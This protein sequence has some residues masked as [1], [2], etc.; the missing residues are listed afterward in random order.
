M[1]IRRLVPLCGGIL[2][3]PSLRLSLRGRLL[4]LVLLAI[5]PAYGL[6]LFSARED[7]RAATAEAQ[8]QT[9]QVA[10]IVA[11]EQNRLIHE[12]EQLLTTLGSLPLVRDADLLPR[13]SEAIA[14]IR[15]QNPMYGNLGVVDASGNM[16]CSAL[17]FKPGMNVADRSWFQRA[18]TR[19]G[20]AV[21]DYLIGRLSGL[22]SLTLSL[23]VADDA[24]GA[25][26]VLFAAVELSW[27]QALAAKLPLPPGT[28]VA[29]VDANGTILARHPDP[30]RTSAGQPAPEKNEL[31]AII[32][33]DCR[34]YAELRGTDGVLRLNAIEPLQRV[35]G[36]CVYVRVGVPRDEIY[37]P[38]EQRSRRNLAAM[39]LVTLLAFAAAWFGSDFLVLRRVRMLG[40]A[41]EQFG[42]GDLTARTG[43]P[44]SKEELGQLARS[45]D[46]MASG[47]EERENRIAEADRVLQRAN[48]ALNVL[49]ASNRAMLRT[50]DERSL[51]DEMCRIVVE[52]GGYAMAWVGYVADEAESRALRPVAHHGVEVE[53]IDARSLSWDEHVSGNA[54]TGAALRSGEAAVLRA[55]PD[56]EPL[57]CMLA[58]GC[59]AA[60][61]FPLASDGIPFGVLTI[62]AREPDAFDQGEIELLGE[63]AAD[64]AFGI[65]KLRDQARRREA[66]EANRIKSEFLANMSHEL[67][68]PLNAI[69]G[70]SEVLKDGLMGELAPPQRE[71]VTDIFTSGRHL[72]SLINDILDLSKVEAGKMELDLE[73][74][75][76]A[77]LLSN[78]LSVIKE[79]AAG[80]GIV[81][82]QEVAD[83][84]P[85]I[86]V[87]P[88]KTKQIIYNL[89][90]NAV[91]FTA[92]QG[93][94]TLRACRARRSE[95][96]NW[97]AGQSK[98]MRLPLP[99]NDFSDF[100]EI[101][102]EDTGIG[103][104]PEDAPRLFQPF[105]QLDS[106]LARR[107]EGTG[108]GLAMVMK[109]AQLHGG[110]VAVASEPGKG[111]CFTV[112]LPW[113]GTECAAAAVPVPQAASSGN[114]LALVLEDNDEAATLIRLQLETE[115]LQVLRV[116]SAEAAL[117]LLATEHPCVIVLDILLPGMDGWDFLARIKQ[118]ASPWADTPVVI[119]SIVADAR[120]GFS[121]GAAQVLQKPVGREDL[122]AA[123]ARLG[124]HPPAHPQSKVLIVDDEVSAVDLLA[125]YLGEP[126]YSALRAY[127]GRE[128]IEMAR[129]E[130]P[131]LLVLDLLMPDVSGFD[132]VQALKAQPE[133]ARI[134]I[135]V[136]TA[137]QV[138]AADR[139]ALNGHVL[140][141]IEKAD[142][143]HEQFAAE[144]RRALALAPQEVS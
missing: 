87:D 58:S 122:A 15:Q 55:A 99:A 102:V 30:Q 59:A 80:H 43:L 41:A 10:T 141:I 125:A 28:A 108:L 32:G 144:V 114:R 139:A 123:L 42:G 9:R 70:F 109:M 78:S 128:G 16:L 1:K 68:T 65:A 56:S 133:T 126:G 93:S 12:A 132:V 94:V 129:R 54:P 79:K 121:L 67:R 2:D 36:K 75:E 61:A 8:R 52:R 51:L 27:L 25:R 98:H 62:Y 18:L 124:L 22:P 86:C 92:A 76:V 40:R 100:L 29:V 113:R 46:E 84:L 104:N 107:F 72:L 47:I 120:R 96:E 101:A 88:R 6:L 38:I 21:G 31:A 83:G 3:S 66:E 131:D 106:S 103:I 13:C 118:A 90:S 71:F 111:S 33:P 89:L 74:T 23:P 112:W 37:A 82:R 77:T 4:L 97:S 19:G 50:R 138:T 49:S 105:S 64:L 60:L 143:D 95:V 135:I 44:H 134:P 117:E 137:K 14:R 110:T 140:T 17:P 119:C 130:H 20:F 69:I 81:L 34:G 91:K 63:A 26:K 57:A 53:R 45:F 48:R 115:G 5:A 24:G 35:G 85:P 39:A 142:F 11:E 7:E 136:V 73:G 127:G 116:G